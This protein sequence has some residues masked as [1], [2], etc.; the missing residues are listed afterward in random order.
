[1]EGRPEEKNLHLL[2]QFANR[3]ANCR[4]Q[5]QEGAGDDRTGTV[6]GFREGARSDQIEEAA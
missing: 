1:M 5:V 6:S 2:R 4:Q 3:Q